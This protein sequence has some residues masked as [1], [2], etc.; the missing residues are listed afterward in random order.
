MFLTKTSVGFLMTFSAL[1]L[2]AAIAPFSFVKN[3]FTFNI[4]VC[5]PQLCRFHVPCFMCF[6]TKSSYQVIYHIST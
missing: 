6:Y 4:I 3:L 2:W 5:I 1:P